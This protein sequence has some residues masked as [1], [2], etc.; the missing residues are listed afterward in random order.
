MTSRALNDTD[1]ILDRAPPDRQPGMRRLKQLGTDFVERRIRI[2]PVDFDA[3][4]H[5]LSHRP[6]GKAHDAGNDRALLLLDDAVAHRLRHRELQF[7]GRDV[8]ARLALD[9]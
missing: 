8:L 3:R 9:A 6:V 4:R 1:D 7:L 2:D 5:D